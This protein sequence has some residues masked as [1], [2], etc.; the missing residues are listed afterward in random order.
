MEPRAQTAH[1]YVLVKLNPA[2]TESRVNIAGGFIKLA[3]PLPAVSARL[4]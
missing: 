3:I 4:L 2:P 1:I